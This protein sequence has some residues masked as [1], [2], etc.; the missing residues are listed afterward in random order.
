MTCFPGNLAALQVKIWAGVKLLGAR[1]PLAAISLLV[2]SLLP[3][4]V[5][6]PCPCSWEGPA[7]SRGRAQLQH[8]GL[9]PQDLLVVAADG[10]QE[11]GKWPFHPLRALPLHTAWPREGFSPAFGALLVAAWI[12]GDS[13]LHRGLSCGFPGMC[14]HPSAAFCCLWVAW[15]SS[16]PSPSGIPHEHNFLGSFSDSPAHCWVLLKLQKSVLGPLNIYTRNV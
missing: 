16:P 15:I 3:A 1:I 7:G 10:D 11:V 12:F 8:R 13:C 14:K 5:R 4:G 2:P 6:D 9:C